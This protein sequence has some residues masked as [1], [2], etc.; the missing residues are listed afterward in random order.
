MDTVIN[1]EPADDRRALDDLTKK[2]TQYQAQLM[3]EQE[4]GNISSI[5]ELRN[6][7]SFL[8]SERENLELNIESFYHV[9]IQSNLFTDS[10]DQLNK[11]SQT[12]ENKLKGRR[13][14]FIP[15]YLRMLEGF[16]T[17]M[18]MAKTYLADK[19]RNLNTGALVAC[20]PFYNSE[21]SHP[22][23]VFIGQNLMTHTPVYVDFYDDKVINN[24]NVSVFG[25]SGSGKTF[26]V[27]LLT[28]R[29]ALKGIRTTI[30]DPEGEYVNFTKALGGAVIDISPESKNKVNVFDI[31]EEVEIDDNK[32]PT[33]RSFVDVKDKVSDL[34][35]L[36]S[37]M[38]P[39]MNPEEKALVSAVLQSLY[40]DFGINN[41]PKSL[42]YSDDFFDELTG[43]LYSVGKRKTMPTFSDFHNKLAKV[44][45]SQPDKQ[46]LIKIV[47]ALS[48]YKKG[49]IYDMFDCQSTIES[50]LFSS[51]PLITFDV[52]K[53]ESNIL[54]PIGMYIALS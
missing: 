23:G 32:R 49:G 30:I 4:K 26:F 20:F 38:Y 3:I 45:E 25:K 17:A 27:S 16:K 33:G 31:E 43:E 51:A 36:I 29:S 15:S 22:N 9:A 40:V 53:L 19:S 35:N 37:V 54:R 14:T 8:Y 41:D 52:H 46:G 5:S 21:L 2:I 1:V 11:E 42:Y 50:S 13:I 28:L 24:T 10:L 48:I 34:L 12:L 39:G 18:P 44:A 7:I 6:K 47:N